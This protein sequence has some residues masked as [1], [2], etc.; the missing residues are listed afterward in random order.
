M[1]GVSNTGGLYDADEIENVQ[2]FSLTK[3][4]NKTLLTEVYRF[5]LES[6]IS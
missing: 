1:R 4:T 5:L 2:V 3:D 6:S